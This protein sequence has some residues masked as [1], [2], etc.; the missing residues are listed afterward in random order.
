MLT[1]G[2]KAR[3]GDTTQYIVDDPLLK[4]YEA[5]AERAQGLSAF[6]R[7]VRMG[8]VPPPLYVGPRMPRWRRSQVRPE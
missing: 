3:Q 8:R 7:D 5:A 6:W 1:S 2:R 4:S